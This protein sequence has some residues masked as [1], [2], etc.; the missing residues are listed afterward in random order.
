MSALSINRKISSLKQ[1]NLFL[2]ENNI[3]S[4]VVIQDKDYIKIQKNNIKKQ[5]PDEKEINK[6]LHTACLDEKNNKRDYCFISIFVYGG[7]RE[8]EIL[9]I[10]LADIH[11]DRRVIGIIGK[12]NKYREVIIN[13]IMYD[14][15]SQYIDERQQINTEN[16]YL[17]LGQKNK[18]TLSPLSRNFGNRLLKKYNKICNIG[19]LH[20][21]ILRAY[22][23]TRALKIG[24]SIAQVADQA[25]HS[26]LNTTK[27]YI[28]VKIEDMISLSNKM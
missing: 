18:N 16:P 22:F 24:Y 3:Q 10:K 17:F 12:G 23:C 8:T 26:S 6:L 9:S 19:K 4:N 27:G 11:F 20:P 5:I 13:D 25:G 28:G 14:A 1:Y 15:I 7:L 21:H 2:L